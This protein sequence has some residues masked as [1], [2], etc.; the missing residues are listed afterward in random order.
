MP[1]APIRSLPLARE[2]FIAAIQRDTPGSDLPRLV[3]VLDIDSPVFR[4]GLDRLLRLADGIAAAKR[5]G[6]LIGGLKRAGLV[7]AVAATFGRLFVLSPKR[8]P[9]PATIRLSPVW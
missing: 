8:N 2:G 6:G 4:A 5:Q 9:L 1:T 7:V 3:A